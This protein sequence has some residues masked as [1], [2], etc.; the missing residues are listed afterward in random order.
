[1]AA[2]ALSISLAFETVFE[3]SYN[4]DPNSINAPSQVRGRPSLAQNVSLI[5]AV[6]AYIRRANMEGSHKLT[7]QFEV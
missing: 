6:Q 2:D 4:K 5:E 7:R 3:P 1:M